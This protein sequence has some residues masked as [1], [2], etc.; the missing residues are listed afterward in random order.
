MKIAIIGG[1]SFIG[2]NLIKHLLKK[3]MR[4]L[5][6]IIQVKKLLKI[7]KLSGKD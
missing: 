7:R 1:T 3:K 4:L 2:E 6:H 5:Q